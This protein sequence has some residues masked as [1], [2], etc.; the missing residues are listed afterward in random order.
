MSGIVNN[1]IFD[2]TAEKVSYH[3]GVRFLGSLP[4]IGV[5]AFVVNH[6]IDEGNS[7]RLALTDKERM[8]THYF[9]WRELTVSLALTCVLLFAIVFSS[10]DVS[11]AAKV[12]LAIAGGTIFGAALITGGITHY[13]RQKATGANDFSHPSLPDSDT[14]KDL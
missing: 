13:Y 11:S 6:L 14:V 12:K 3:G 4:A 8:A 5:V 7:S 10:H 1:N 2:S 9:R